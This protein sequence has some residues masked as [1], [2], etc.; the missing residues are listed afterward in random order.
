MSIA[1]IE[2]ELKFKLKKIPDCFLMDEVQITNMSQSYLLLSESTKTQLQT[3]FSETIDWSHIKEAR[4][5]ISYL[6][7]SGGSTWDCFLTLKSD[8]TLQ[9]TEWETEIKLEQYWSLMNLPMIGNITKDR[10]GYMIHDLGVKIELDKYNE[11]LKGLIT[12]EVE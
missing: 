4:V 10:Y 2:T 1:K 5:R 11:S 3:F 9:R 6:S 7:F 12:A 8:G